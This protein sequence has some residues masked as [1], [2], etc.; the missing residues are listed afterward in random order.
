LRTVLKGSTARAGH[1]RASTML[2]S[3]L[4]TS[5]GREDG[6]SLVWPM[7]SYGVH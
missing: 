4:R 7:K 3:Y 6:M 5:F 2:D 1:A